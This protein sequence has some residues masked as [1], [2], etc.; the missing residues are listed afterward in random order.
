L[1][2]L[3]QNGF[4][5]IELSDEEVKMSSWQDK[6]GRRREGSVG[7]AFE[8]FRRSASWKGKK[9]RT[10]ED[11][12]RGWRYIEPVFGDRPASKITFEHLDR[13]YARL[14]DK[15]GVDGAYRA[16][17]TWRSIYCVMAS[18]KLVT[19]AGPFPRYPS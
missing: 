15:H 2:K 9:L 5:G 14:L 3:K 12:E 10:R 13:W 4:G 11:W 18:M 1:A 6:S 8:R 17:K 16:M 19:R 7:D